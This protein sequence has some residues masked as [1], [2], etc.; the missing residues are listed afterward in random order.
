MSANDPFN[1]QIVL[2]LTGKPA[3]SIFALKKKLKQVPEVCYAEYVHV[4]Q[5]TA[6]LNAQE[7]SMVERLL[8][9]G[10]SL[11]LAQA[12]GKR[13][14]TVMPRTGTISPWSSKA[15]DILAICGLTKIERVERGVRWFVHDDANVKTVDQQ[16]LHDRMTQ[17]CFIDEDFAAVFGHQSPMPVQN[18][19][20]LQNGQLALHDANVQ[21]GLA[22]SKDEIDYL[23]AAYQQLQRDPTDAELMMFA[24]ANSEHCRHKIFN[25]QWLI[26][27]QLQEKSLFA[28]IRNT[29][30]RINGRS[31]L[32][33]YSDNAA[34]IEGAVD[35]RL[36][37]DPNSGEYRYQHEPVHILMK[38]ETH[39]HPTAIAPFA[40]A[41]TGSGGEIRDEGAVGRGS[42]PKA[43]MTGFTTSHLNIPGMR[44]PWEL[45]TGKPAHMASALDIMLEGPIGAASF[46]NEF[47]RPAIN[48]YF[49]TFELD[50]DGVAR[51]YH[52]PV[53]IAGGIGA[54][55][56]EHVQR[57]YR[58]F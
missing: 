48:G 57:R 5:L 56:E 44:Q 34:V 21:L 36:W 28:M 27:G 19:A 46:N 29:Y 4:L 8:D 10:P 3:L 55:R 54:V 2:T 20:V 24:Q 30:Q 14:M 17:S 18:V 22:L 1:Q 16:H 6:P 7:T 15:T 9:Y 39:N 40:G 53:M 41:A 38:V 47:G 11:D 13:L 26:D 50:V 49:R 51:G 23:V 33:A 43:G 25:A 58:V 31:I 42:K 32:S 12:G 37:V 45:E 52:K 35:A